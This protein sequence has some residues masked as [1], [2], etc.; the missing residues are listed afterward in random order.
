MNG[1]CLRLWA[2]RRWSQGTG[3]SNE[4][5]DVRQHSLLLLPREPLVPTG[6]GG[7]RA[8]IGDDLEEVLVRLGGGL[9]GDQIPGAGRERSGPLAITSTLR[10]VAICAMSPINRPYLFEV[11]C[12]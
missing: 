10:A 3:K 1:K 7:A 8:P 11:R 4:R 2:W 5:S 6:H 12:S 9:C